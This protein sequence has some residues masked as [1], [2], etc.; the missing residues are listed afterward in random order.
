M[1]GNENRLVLDRIGQRLDSHHCYQ[2][3]IK[4]MVKL[5]R[6]RVHQ[7]ALQPF[8]YEYDDLRNRAARDVAVRRLDN[9]HGS[10]SANR[11][12]SSTLGLLSSA[13]CIEAPTVNEEADPPSVPTGLRVLL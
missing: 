2:L 7:A 5:Q 1:D 10:R 8:F 3:R 4:Q 13:W 6:V 9:W 11:Y 12:G